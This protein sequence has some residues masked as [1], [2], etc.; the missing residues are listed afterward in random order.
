MLL[1]VLEE[2]TYSPALITAVIG[3]KGME[4]KV[5]EAVERGTS[6]IDSSYASRC[7]HHVFFLCGAA[8]VFEKCRFTC[9]C[10]ACQE[11]GVAGELHQVKGGLELRIGSI[12]IYVYWHSF[13]ISLEL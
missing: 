4:R 1:V 2:V 9:P 11:Y 8:D 10:F 6:S 13:I 3:H 12:Y 5:E 7:K